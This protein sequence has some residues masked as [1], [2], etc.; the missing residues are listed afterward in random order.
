MTFERIRRFQEL[1]RSNGID[2]SLIR[3]L[4]SFTYFAG[5]KWLRPGLTKF[6]CEARH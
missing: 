2:A 3:T 1:M 6:A 5:V 4:S